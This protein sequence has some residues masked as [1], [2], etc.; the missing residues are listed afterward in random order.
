MYTG[1]GMKLFRYIL[2]HIL[3]SKLFELGLENSVLYY[4]YRGGGL[5]METIH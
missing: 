1:K 4:P 2:L 3:D 5:L